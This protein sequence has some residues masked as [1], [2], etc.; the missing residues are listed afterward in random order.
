MESK[1]GVGLDIWMGVKDNGKYVIG[2]IISIF[3]FFNLFQNKMRS[4]F[5]G[6]I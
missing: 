3:V 4:I 6:I 5:R 2:K 1:R